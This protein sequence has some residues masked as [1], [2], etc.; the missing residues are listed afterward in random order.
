MCVIL[1]GGAKRRSRRTHLHLHTLFAEY[2]PVQP[3]EIYGVPGATAGRMYFGTN[4][5]CGT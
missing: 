4:T 3:V 5:R 1:S 2:A